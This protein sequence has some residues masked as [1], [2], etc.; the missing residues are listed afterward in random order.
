[1]AS[2]TTAAVLPPRGL[3]HSSCWLAQ[4]SSPHLSKPGAYSLRSTSTASRAVSSQTWRFDEPGNRRSI[5]CGIQLWH[6]TRRVVVTGVRG[7]G[8]IVGGAAVGG[9]AGG[10][11]G[12]GGVGLRAVVGEVGV[13]VR[14]AGVGS[15]KLQR[16]LAQDTLSVCRLLKSS[17][18]GSSSL[19]LSSS[20]PSSSSSSS[21]SSSLRLDSVPRAVAEDA[22]QT[23][24]SVSETSEDEADANGGTTS[25]GGE[26]A[27]GVSS[28][29]GGTE[30]EPTEASGEVRDGPSSSPTPAIDA[31]RR[32][33]GGGRQRRTVSVK[34]Q[35]L[36]L[37]QILQGTV[38]SIQSYGA[39]VDIGSSTDGLLHISQ[40]ENFFVKEVQDV[41]AVGQEVAVRIIDVDLDKGRIS[42]SMKDPNQVDQRRDGS[43]AENSVPRSDEADG[44]MPQARKIAGRGRKSPTANKDKATHNFKKGQTVKGVVKNILA[45]GAFNNRISLSMREKVDV[46][47]I[48]TDMNV[49][50]DEAL[51][52][53]QLAFR[54]ANLIRDSF[55]SLN[56]DADAAPSLADE[57]E[58]KDA[59]STEGEEVDVAPETEA[60][61]EL[62]DAAEPSSTDEN[63]QLEIAGAAEAIAAESQ[64]VDELAAAEELKVEDAVESIAVPMEIPDS[65][66]SE[67]T[68]D[69]SPGN[70]MENADVSAEVEE[71]EPVADST[72]VNV[73]ENADASAEVDEPE[74]AAAAVLEP[75]AE[76][77][78]DSTMVEVNESTDAVPSVEQSQPAVAEATAEQTDSTDVSSSVALASD[79]SAQ[80]E[81]TEKPSTS[82]D[83]K[84]TAAL[85]KELRE[86]TGAGMMDCKRA[87]EE[88]KGDKSKA[89]DLLRKRGLA[90]ADKKAARIAAE[91]LIVSYIHDNRIGVLLELN[92]ETDF[93][94]RGEKF[95]ELADEIAMQV[96][97]CQQV[98][99][100]DI[101]EIPESVLHTER[102]IEMGK[103]DIQNKPEAI[104][105]KIVEG[106][107]TKRLGEVCL[108][109]LPYIRNDK[110]SVKDLVK[111]AV[112]TIGENIR[113]RRFVRYER[114]EGIEKKA[115]DFAQDV[116][117]Q[118][119]AMSGATSQENAPSAA[120]PAPAPAAEDA[121]P[122]PEASPAAKPVPLAVIQQLRQETGAGVMDC[123]KAVAEADG[124]VEKAREWLRKKG[125]ASAEKKASRTAAEGVIAS[126]VHDSRIGVVAEINCETDFVARGEK[127]QELVEDICMQI[128][129]SA[130]VVAVS[131]SDIPEEFVT[132]EREIEMGKEDILS[133]PE[134]IRGKIVEGRVAKRL[135]E[136]ALLEQPFIRNDKILVKDYIK[137]AVA[138]LGENITVRR[139]EKFVLGEG[140]E[141]RVTDFAAEVAAQAGGAA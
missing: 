129:A 118:M 117:E 31:R 110:L 83:V 137:E 115:V 86:E 81:E 50:D 71:P 100:V 25:Q 65:P 42:L 108:M 21:L 126:Y 107:V 109:E 134:A 53:F 37:G 112:A 78:V 69:S 127:F 49:G 39:F 35:D 125:L 139:F 17:E 1:M 57:L 6:R 45:Y 43:Q 90:K 99:Y 98:K 55:P 24:A 76:A 122:N 91:G 72:P 113:I 48:N 77:A 44:A 64:G 66:V 41:V 11:R 131:V 47:R 20:S 4:P 89:Q 19:F 28:E 29:A 61:A 18:R 7:G 120:P 22:P 97:A 38:K 5:C 114:G 102:S 140:L 92:C 104:R 46:S 67:A 103:D 56:P 135:N 14:A 141:K 60:V 88:T 27:D 62:E 85:V 116:A 133:K 23:L 12:A 15:C 75:V 74:P 79:L 32:A 84:I 106:R 16:R 96:A 10:G 119:K 51:K 59:K 95:R 26:I 2:A 121:E 54:R 30:I 82:S 36:Q 94:A 124:D 128:A 9:R 136:L 68:D 34:I 3:L 101:S 130:D 123:K 33:R 138:L 105:E 111:Q 8:V 63:A 132:K 87:L 52:P 70:V 58:V 13:G 93:V 80:A 73:L 40:L